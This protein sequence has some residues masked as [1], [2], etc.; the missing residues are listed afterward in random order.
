MFPPDTR[1]SICIS[2]CSATVIKHHGQGNLWKSSF[3]LTDTRFRGHDGN[4]GNRIRKQ[5][6]ILN[7]KHQRNREGVGGEADRDTERHRERERE[8]TRKGANS[9]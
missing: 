6:N 4:I 3:E 1:F 9:K 7:H 8:H 2:H 5:D